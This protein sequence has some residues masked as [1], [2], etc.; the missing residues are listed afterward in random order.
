MLLLDKVFFIHILQIILL[1]LQSFMHIPNQKIHHFLVKNAANDSHF[2][3]T[4][5]WETVWKILTSST[6]TFQTPPE[7]ELS[8][9]LEFL[10]QDQKKAYSIEEMVETSCQNALKKYAKNTY[11]TPSKREKIFQN[12]YFIAQAGEDF[13]EEWEATQSFVF[14]QEYQKDV[15]EFL[16]SS[17]GK[18]M[19]YYLQHHHSQTPQ[20]QIGEDMIHKTLDEMFQYHAS[21]LC[22][23]IS[24]HANLLVRNILEKVIYNFLAEHKIDLSS[25]LIKQRFQEQIIQFVEKVSFIAFSFFATFEYLENDESLDMIFETDFQLEFIEWFLDNYP[26]TFSQ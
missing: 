13:F 14:H 23:E 9:V 22:P 21:F 2:D 3:T 7:K 12:M 25:D 11:V 8:N 4:F 20:F 5:V 1:F 26:F 17:Y 16:L 10:F 18:N 19:T 24:D 6:D 15:I